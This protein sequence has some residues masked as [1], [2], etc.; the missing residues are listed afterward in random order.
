MHSSAERRSLLI[1]A[2][3][4]L[5][6]LVAIA[7][8]MTLN[9]RGSWDFVLPFRGRK[10]W[11]MVLVGY[12]IAVSTVLFQTVSGNRILS[13]GIMGFDWLYSLVQTTLVF[14]L[15]G[16]AYSTLDP[17]LRFAGDVLVM[18]VLST[19][20]FRWL[21]GGNSRDLYLLVLVGIVFGV[22]FRSLSNLMQRMIDPNEFVVLQ[23]ALFASFNTIDATLLVVATVLM[24]LVSLLIVPI[25]GRLDV[26]LLGRDPALGLGVDHVRTVSL[27]LVVIAVLV[28]VSTA[29]V[30]PVLFFGLLVSNLAYL[31]LPT[32]RHA[33][34]LPA[35]AML[36]VIG[37]VGGQAVL[38]HVFGYN[39]AL[40]IIIEFVG[41]ITFLVLIMR[42]SRA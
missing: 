22:M 37:L 20:L 6:M 18:V 1:L 9:A 28:S 2:G 5:A 7:L 4:G 39:T 30:G 10:V 25:L 33:Y 36:A 35:A 16:F 40:A 31:I 27:V 41:G 26:L 34:V 23:D 3:L 21:F 17:Q 15:G 14:V 38:E 42:R 32:Y 24:A 11:G 8:F 29:L 13:P 19:A 12:A